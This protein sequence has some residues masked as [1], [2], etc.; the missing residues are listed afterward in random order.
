MRVAAIY[1]DCISDGPGVRVSVYFS[2]CL[3]N[4]CGGSNCPGCHNPA[5]QSFS[6]GR[7]Y[8]AEVKR[9]ILDAASKPYI[10]GITLAGGEPYDQDED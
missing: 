1:K 5:A 10:K 9:E 8:T 6:Y 7:L 3:P 4:K 2:G